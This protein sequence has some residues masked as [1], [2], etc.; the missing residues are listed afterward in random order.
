MEFLLED[1]KCLCKFKNQN[2]IQVN[3]NDKKANENLKFLKYQNGFIEIKAHNYDKNIIGE[4]T[5]Y[6]H[7][8]LYYELARWSRG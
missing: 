8:E 6:P 1:F 5:S 3:S 4:R 2:F 7:L